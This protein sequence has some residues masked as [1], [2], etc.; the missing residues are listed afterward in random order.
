METYQN[1]AHLL[2]QIQIN[3]ATFE[4]RKTGGGS[5]NC[6]AGKL[7]ISTFYTSL[8]MSTTF[9]SIGGG[10]VDVTTLKMARKTS[11]VAKGK[12]SRKLKSKGN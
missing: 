12:S 9:L 3:L 5:A 1:I 10:V 2:G 8:F 4:K 6:E 7:S 11:E